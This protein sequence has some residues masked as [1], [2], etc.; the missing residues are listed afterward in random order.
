[1][2]GLLYR[3][4]LEAPVVGD[5]GDDG[6]LLDRRRNLRSMCP[7]VSNVRLSSEGLHEKPTDVEPTCTGGC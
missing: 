1:M 5:K 3:V 4:S 6:T 2:R 7:K